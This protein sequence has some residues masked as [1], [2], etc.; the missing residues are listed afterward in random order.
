MFHQRFHIVGHYFVEPQR[1]FNEAMKAGYV[2]VRTINTLMFGMAGTGKTSVRCILF[3]QPPPDV[4]HSTPLA[5]APE[6][7]YIR[8]VTNIKA[9]ARRDGWAPVT[10]EDLKQLL[11]NTIRSVTE[12]MEFQ[13]VPVDLEELLKELEPDVVA[14]AAG[15]LATSSSE[16]DVTKDVTDTSSNKSHDGNDH[17]VAAIAEVVGKVK[18]SFE[19]AVSGRHLRE[20]LDSIWVYFTDSG[21]QLHFHNLLPLFI[22]GVSAAI[23]TFRLSEGFDDHPVVEYYKDGKVVGLSYTSPFTNEESFKYLVRSLQTRCVEGK[24]PMLICVGTHLDMKD[25]CEESLEKKK[26]RLL[27]VLDPG[28]RDVLLFSDEHMTEPI[29]TFNAK[30]PGSH[31]EDMAKRLRSAI[32]G[33]TPC[34]CKIPIWWYFLE[35]LLEGFTRL[36]D[37]KVLS[38][39][40]C[41]VIAHK[42]KFHEDALTEALKLF[43]KHH[44][45]H[46]Y[47]EALPDVIFCDTQVLLDKVTELVEYASFLR[48]PAS[49]TIPVQSQS[50]FP[51]HGKW[52]H[53]RDEGVIT[54][55]FLKDPKFKQ[56]FVEGLFG[57]RE[58]IEIFKHLLVVTP[59]S[60]TLDAS[61]RSEEFFMP[62]LL[63]IL[64]PPDLDKHR[65]FSSEA[66][67]LLIRYPNGWPRCGVFCCLQV[68]LIHNCNWKISQT[69]ER[70]PK[71]CTQNCVKMSYK[72]CRVT[73]IDSFSYIEVHVEAIEPEDYKM[74]CPSLVNDIMNGIEASCKALSYDD[75]QPHLAYFCPCSDAGSNQRQC[76]ASY[77]SDPTNQQR[78]AAIVLTE[79]NRLQ[80][81]V[82]TDVQSKL[83]KRHSPWLDYLPDRGEC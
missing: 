47:P 75:E 23:F 9:Q 7:V 1:L 52:S 50:S 37:R 61:S 5:N 54:L 31:E 29:F 20:P 12:N 82:D 13:N 51:K 15:D 77:L 17:I 80:C 36:H 67:P 44:I 21:G 58:L 68:Y 11:V 38:K 27:E 55:E 81:T 48:Q 19:T 59:L 69:K 42:L 46:Y 24:R 35:I 66:A 16:Q 34:D 70:R 62:S 18:E 32:E 49:S 76:S 26:E 74:V 22:R 39:D 83:E 60:C 64:P 28:T 3:G 41:L 43:H 79:F 72:V 56:H 6:R 78:H 33:C 4:H 53:F 45:F 8:N 30:N 63:D 10:V 73:L 14:K 71:L 2:K 65:V 25:K 40:E 57:P